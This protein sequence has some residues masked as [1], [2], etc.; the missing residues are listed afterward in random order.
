MTVSHFTYKA[1]QKVPSQIC[2]ANQ[3]NASTTDSFL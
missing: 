1:K 3:V 2:L